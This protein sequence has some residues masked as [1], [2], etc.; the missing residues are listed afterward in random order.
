LPAAALPRAA[1][2]PAEPVRPT[3]ALFASSRRHGNTG[4]LMDSVAEALK[5]QV[6]DLAT[7]ELSPFDYEHKNRGDDFEP[8][9]EYVLGF[10]QII[11]ASPVYWYA[12]SPPMKVFIDRISDLLDVPDLL[13]T[14]RRLRGKY[15]HVLCTSIEEQPTPSF[16]NAFRETFDYL[17]MRYGALL[18]AN[19]RDGYVPSLY[20]EDVRAFIRQLQAA[21]Q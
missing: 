4:R 1:E 15:V 11:F 2:S 18:H 20:E 3:V 14:G 16:V 7:R 12:V 19:C 8:L 17:G 5:I 9:M 6:I 10:E 21:P 13:A